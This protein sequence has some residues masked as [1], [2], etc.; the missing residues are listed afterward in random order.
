LKAIGVDE[1]RFCPEPQH[2]QIVKIANDHA[3]PMQRAECLVQIA[4][5]R[6]HGGM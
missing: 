2:I 6:H 5:Q 1:I 3:G 4:K